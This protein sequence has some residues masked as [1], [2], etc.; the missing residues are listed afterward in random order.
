MEEEG[1]QIQDNVIAADE[2]D[3]KKYTS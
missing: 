3:I 1:E 2:A